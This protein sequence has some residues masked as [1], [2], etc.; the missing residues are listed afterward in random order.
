MFPFLPQTGQ[1]AQQIAVRPSSLI[2]AQGTEEL[3]ASA[4]AGVGAAG[5]DPL[6]T[7]P[8]YTNLTPQSP[9][10]MFLPCLHKD[11]KDEKQ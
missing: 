4:L 3:A 5:R 8:L 11:K 9:F 1:T 7:H 10:F 6:G 2:P